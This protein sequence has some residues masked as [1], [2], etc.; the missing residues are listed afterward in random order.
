MQNKVPLINDGGRCTIGLESTVID[1]TE[2][3]P[4]LLRPGGVPAEDIENIIGKITI[5]KHA[6]E[7]PKSPGMK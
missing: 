6:G 1:I 2:H 7:K 5:T 4:Q 3:P